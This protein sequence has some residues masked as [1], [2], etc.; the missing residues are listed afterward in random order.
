[1][2]RFRIDHLLTAITLKFFHLLKSFSI[3]KLTLKAKRA[4]MPVTINFCFRLTDFATLEASLRTSVSSI[5]TIPEDL[6]DEPIII[7]RVLRAIQ[8]WKLICQWELWKILVAQK[9]VFKNISYFI[10]HNLLSLIC[11]FCQMSLNIISWLLISISIFLV[12]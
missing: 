2:K 5:G 10:L 8:L 11:K 9:R 12:W 4:K 1:M 6:H 3:S 7:K